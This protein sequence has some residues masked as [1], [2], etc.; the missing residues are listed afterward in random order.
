MSRHTLDL[1]PRRQL[2]GI[3][4]NQQ[5]RQSRTRVA[6]QGAAALDAWLPPSKRAATS[7][8]ANSKE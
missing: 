5:L 4:V 8:I 1:I 6:Q 7:R 2:H 3:S